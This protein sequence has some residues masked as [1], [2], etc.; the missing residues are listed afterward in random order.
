MGY[1]FLSSNL[2]QHLTM[3]EIVAIVNL[4]LFEDEDDESNLTDIFSTMLSN[5]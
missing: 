3:D 4:D 5:F 2:K 1:E